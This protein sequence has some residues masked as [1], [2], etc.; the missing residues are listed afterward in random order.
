MAPFGRSIEKQVQ[1]RLRALLLEVPSIRLKDWREE[2]R[3]GGA[4]VDLVLD[5]AAGGERWRLLLQCKGAGEPRIVR[6]AIQELRELI[7]GQRKAYGVVAAPYITTRGAEICKASGI[8]FLDLA[9]NCRLVF[10]KVFIERLGLPN[11]KVER[12]PLRTLFAPRASRVIRVLFEEP[13]R[14]WQVQELAKQAQVSLGLA[15]KVK[16]RLLDLEYAREEED[17][18]HLARPEALVRE[19]T[20]VYSYQK[21]AVLD[22]YGLLEVPDLEAAFSN[23]CRTK[24][25]R[26]AL[27]LFSGA[28]RVAAFTRYARAFA[29]V[30]ADT[31][32]V[33]R[34]LGL[35]PVPSGANFTIMTPFDEGILYGAQKVDGATVVSDVQLY[36]DLAGYKGRG[37]EA[38]EFILD[39]RLRPR[40]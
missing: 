29:Y 38:A 34:E 22:C 24:G 23:Y 4:R 16:E 28:A 40:W 11:M 39:K 26:Y 25:I 3:L 5:L 14:A 17:G 36:L 1:E 30:V 27:A 19:W 32:D 12:R 37:E 15:F 31:A 18:I 20:S 33:A 6:A 10:G 35:K 8:G 7:P 9:G 13:K 2:A 21:N